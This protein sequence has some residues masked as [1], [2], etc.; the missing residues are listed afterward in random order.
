MEAGKPPID[1]AKVLN[2]IIK[3]LTELLLESLK[4]AMTGMYEMEFDEYHFVLSDG[5]EN[6]GTGSSTADPDTAA[7]DDPDRILE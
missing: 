4:K 3:I 5:T 7:Y 2:V 1:W 6:S